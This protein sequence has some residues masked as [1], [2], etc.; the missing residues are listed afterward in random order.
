MAWNG[1]KDTIEITGKMN[2]EAALLLIENRGISSHL[3]ILLN[4]DSYYK[5]LQNCFG[6]AASREAAQFTFSLI[7]ADT[8]GELLGVAIS[9]VSVKKIFQVL[10]YFI[11]IISMKYPLAGYFIVKATMISLFYEFLKHISNNQQKNMEEKKLKRTSLK[12]DI[13]LVEVKKDFI[14]TRSLLVSTLSSVHDI[15]DQQKTALQE[16]IQQIDMQ[17]GSK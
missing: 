17:L 15:T 7:L 14:E 2:V 16:Q 13:E 11:K 5:A 1:I 12:V 9:I 4:S 3:A 8:S 10:S 6:E